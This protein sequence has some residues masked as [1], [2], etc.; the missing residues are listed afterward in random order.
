MA[1]EKPKAWDKLK[2]ETE[3]AYE[4]FSTYRDLGVG[5][6]FVAVAEKLQKSYT[7]I[8]RWANKHNWEERAAAYDSSVTEGTR[9][10]NVNSFETAIKRKNSIASKLEEKALAALE[11]LNLSRVSGRT[12]VEMLTLSNTLRNEAFEIENANDA[13]SQVTSIEIKRRGD[14]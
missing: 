9:K 2:D 12:I 14:D 13:D 8:R 4:A 11:N 10:A 1:N 6:T 5:R 7:L 3:K